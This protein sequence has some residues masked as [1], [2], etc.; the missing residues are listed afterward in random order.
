M[1]LS[2]WLF[3]EVAILLPDN[4]LNEALAGPAWARS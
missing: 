4:R 1:A 3:V 2:S